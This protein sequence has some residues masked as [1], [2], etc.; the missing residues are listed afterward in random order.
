MTRTS[1]DAQ[2]V[3][4]PER[5]LTQPDHFLKQPYLDPMALDHTACGATLLARVLLHSDDGDLERPAGG[6]GPVHWLRG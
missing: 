3:L 6:L 2:L 4:R 1:V 5:A